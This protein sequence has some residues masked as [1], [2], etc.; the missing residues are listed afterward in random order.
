MK[1]IFNFLT[2]KEWH[3]IFQRS[4]LFYTRL[5]HIIISDKLTWIRWDIFTSVR[6]LCLSVIVCL[7]VCVRDYIKRNKQIIMIFYV[8]LDKGIN[9]KIG[10]D[11][12]YILDTKISLIFRSPVF[13][14]CSMVLAFWLPLTH[15]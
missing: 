12:N 1:Y 7:F 3:S 11:S 5:C 2:A 10:K 6:R 9:E 4:G 14:I 15:K 13:S 8:G